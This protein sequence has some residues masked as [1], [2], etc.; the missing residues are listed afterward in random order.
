[1]E[2]LEKRIDE[3]ERKLFVDT[4]EQP[5][6]VFIEPQD[7]SLDAEPPCPFECWSFN[8]HRIT[9]H[10]GE[11]DEAFRQ[12]AIDEVKSSLGKMAVPVFLGESSDQIDPLKT[13]D[14][15]HGA[16][17]ADQNDTQIFII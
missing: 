8:G 15:W 11:T 1:M 13:A 12:R 17:P 3:L 2:T 10:A 4:D 6:G 7:A 9:R 14:R 5:E 16:K